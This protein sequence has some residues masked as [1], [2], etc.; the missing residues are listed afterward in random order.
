MG[1]NLENGSKKFQN[2]RLMSIALNELTGGKYKTAIDDEKFENGIQIVRDET[3]RLRLLLD[4][5]K[6]QPEILKELEI[7]IASSQPASPKQVRSPGPTVA[8]ARKQSVATG[9]SPRAR[10]PV[11]ERQASKRRA[12]SD[13]SVASV[14]QALDGKGNISSPIGAAGESRRR[15]TS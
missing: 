5:L 15:L 11:L 2:T 7:R 6:G 9:I 8:A 1:S 4:L 12:D 3:K 10:Q 14:R 13:D